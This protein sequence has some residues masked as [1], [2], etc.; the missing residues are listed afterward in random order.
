MT[1]PENRIVKIVEPNKGKHVAVT[2]DINT[3]VLSIQYR[4]LLN[5]RQFG[6]FLI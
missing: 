2:G 3:I 5:N 4:L 1:Y 6:W